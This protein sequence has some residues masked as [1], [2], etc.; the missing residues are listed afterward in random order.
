MRDTKTIKQ[1]LA[2]LKKAGLYKGDLR[3]NKFSRRQIRK[4]T[5]YADVIEGRAKA[6]KF[7]SKE[8]KPYRQ[9]NNFRIFNNRLIVE[10]SVPYQIIE[11]KNGKIKKTTFLKKGSIVEIIL[12]YKATD[13]INLA[14]KMENDENL[15]ERL[16]GEVPGKRAMYGFSIYGHTQIKTFSTKTELV[17]HIKNN[18]QTLLGIGSSVNKFSLVYFND[19][20]SKMPEI[21]EEISGEAEYSEGFSKFGKE[22]ASGRSGGTVSKQVAERRAIRFKGYRKNLKGKKLEK[23]KKDAIARANKSRNNK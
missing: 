14:T 8:L 12:P 16:K 11:N 18:Y 19:E 1:G 7:T 22:N 6:V 13:I 15:P 10:K 2:I 3:K 23:Y 21:P 20:G 17:N 4:L 9:A 5:I